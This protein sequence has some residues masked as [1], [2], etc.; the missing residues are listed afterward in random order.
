MDSPDYRNTS[1]AGQYNAALSPRSPGSTLKP[2]AYALA[3]DRGQ[4]TPEEVLQGHSSPVARY[5]PQNFD[6]RFRQRVSARQ[7]LV[8]SLNLP[9]IEV[10][11]R[12]GQRPFL[13]TLHDLGLSTLDKPPEHYGLNLILGGGEVRLLTYLVPTQN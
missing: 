4:L 9:S 5:Q 13:E 12:I 3:F 8:D 2:F 1:Q 7:A 11:R 10:V 6:R